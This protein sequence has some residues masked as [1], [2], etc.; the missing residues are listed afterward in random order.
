M[1]ILAVIPARYGSQRL[2]GK[3]MSKIGDR[4]MIQWV[5]EAAKNCADFEQV[6]VATDN[7]IV[8]DCVR[9]F[10]GEVEM[11][12]ANHTTGTDRVA[13]VADRYPEM[14]ADIDLPANHH[15]KRIVNQTQPEMNPPPAGTDP[16]AAA[17][18]QLLQQMANTMKEMQAQIM[19]KTRR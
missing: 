6:V 18:M 13:E 3:V 12:R 4:P 5:Y 15:S 1:K 19:H 8:A 16:I 2:P 7:Q 9:Q 17:Q 10:G 14:T 11:T